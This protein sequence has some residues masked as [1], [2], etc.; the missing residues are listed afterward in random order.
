MESLLESGI[1]EVFRLMPDTSESH[2]PATPVGD[3]KGVTFLE[4]SEKQASKRGL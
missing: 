1:K 3:A 2:R 4:K